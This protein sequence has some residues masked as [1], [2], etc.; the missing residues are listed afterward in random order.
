LQEDPGV[1][2]WAETATTGIRATA[3][4]SIKLLKRLAFML[5]RKE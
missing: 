3:R 5:I 4:A 1:I 2:F